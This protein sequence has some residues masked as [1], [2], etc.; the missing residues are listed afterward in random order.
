MKILCVIDSLG[1]G[2][3]QRQLVTI[4]IGLKKRGHQIHFLLYHQDNHFLPLLISSNISC[5]VI[6]KCSYIKKAIIIRKIIRKGWQD[7]VLAFLE[8]P[9]FYVEIAKIPKQKWRLIISE[10]SAN[11]NIKNKLAFFMKQFHRMADAIICNSYANKLM[12]ECSY[13]FLVSK[14][15]TIYNIVDF[16]IFKETEQEKKVKTSEM[17][18]VVAA[19]YNNNKNM[20]NVAKAMVILKD[21]KKNKEIII[22]WYGTVRDIVQYEKVKKYIKEKGLEDIFRLNKA[23]GEI[24]KEMSDADAVGLFSFYE[25]LPNSV[26]EGMACGKPILLSKVC[27][28][29]N[30]VND[31]KNG[32]LCD[33]NNPEDIAAK[34]NDLANKSDEERMCMGI[35]SRKKAKLLFC[36]DNIIERYESILREAYSNNIKKDGYNWP[37]KVPESAVDTVR[38]WR[39]R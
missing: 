24:E 30:L 20:M 35:E 1:S 12:L 10:R 19:S 34:I 2:G 6:K 32:F 23:S 9:S 31:G 33:P 18:I 11:P 26:C 21:I 25:G 7:I 22:D 4:A 28:A 15:H 13:P 16:S 14:L 17:R 36:E 38:L 5:E 39:K 8:A 3:A 29:T 27:D 37:N